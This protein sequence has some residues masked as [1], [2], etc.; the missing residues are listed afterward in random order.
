MGDVVVVVV[1]WW[2]GMVEG[3]WCVWWVG[4]V[5]VGDG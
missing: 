5:R 4:V 1:E 3:M 2:L